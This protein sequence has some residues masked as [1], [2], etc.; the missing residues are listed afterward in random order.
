MTVVPSTLLAER[1]WEV[2][3]KLDQRTHLLIAEHLK[4]D[5]EQGIEVKPTDV[6]LTSYA[7]WMRANL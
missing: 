7:C 4:R 3:Q 2:G 1:D 6:S 5:Y